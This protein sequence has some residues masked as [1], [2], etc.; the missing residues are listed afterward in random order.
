MKSGR[1]DDEFVN[2]GVQEKLQNLRCE[3]RYGG[4]G[5][6]KNGWGGPLKLHRMRQT[7]FLALGAIEMPPGASH[8]RKRAPR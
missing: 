8:R 6:L 7:H 5:Q 1:V 4:G 3:L 2:S